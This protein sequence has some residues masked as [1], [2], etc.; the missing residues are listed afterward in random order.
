MFNNFNQLIKKYRSSKGLQIGLWIM[1]IF[2]LLG[3]VWVVGGAGSQPADPLVQGSTMNDDTGK[4]LL[5][6]FIKLMIVLV[7]IYVVFLVLR[8]WQSGKVV[9]RKRRLSIAETLRLSPRQSICLVRV[10]SRELLVGVTDQAMSLL[11]EVD[12]EEMEAELPQE[13]PMAMSFGDA[14]QQSLGNVLHA[15]SRGKKGG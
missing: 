13:A 11:S 7:L 10:G 1:G 15:N 2:V 8:R 9:A 3:L 4:M 6:A 14:F 12:P 5:D